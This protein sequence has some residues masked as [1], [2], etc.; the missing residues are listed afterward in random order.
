VSLRRRPQTE[1][2]EHHRFHIAGPG[3]VVKALLGLPS[4][5]HG[6]A[7]IHE[8]V[9]VGAEI[10][11]IAQGTD[12]FFGGAGTI[13]IAL[14]DHGAEEEDGGVDVGEFAVPF[15]FSRG[16]FQEMVVKAA[17]RGGGHGL[18]VQPE[19][20]EKLQRVQD[21]LCGL[22]AREKAALHGDGK[23]GQ[24]ESGGGDAAGAFGRIAVG[25]QAGFERCGVDEVG[26][27]TDLQRVEKRVLRGRISRRSLGARQHGEREGESDDD[28]APD[29]PG[30]GFFRHDA[31]AGEYVKSMKSFVHVLRTSA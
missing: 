1:D 16:N 12:R 8:P 3:G 9:P 27:G 15:A 17:V 26:Q 6:L 7:A 20:V 4:H 18:R 11:G 19:L 28:Q 25:R 24:G 5:G 23:G 2:V 21:A 14:T 13:E 10:E 29:T 30:A 22:L 31:S